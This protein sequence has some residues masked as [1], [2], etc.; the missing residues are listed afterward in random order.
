MSGVLWQVRFV[1]I[2]G[3]PTHVLVYYYASAAVEASAQKPR[4]VVPLSEVS[5]QRWG[6]DNCT[7]R[8]K[9]P[10]R[11]YEFRAH[12]PEECTEWI[13][14][15]S[16]A[17]EVARRARSAKG[18]GA[19]GGRPAMCRDSSDDDNDATD[20]ASACGSACGSGKRGSLGGTEAAYP[21]GRSAGT[22]SA[23]RACG[24]SGGS[25]GASP[26]ATRAAAATAR[27]GD[28]T[29]ASVAPA[30]GGGANATLAK[31]RNVRFT[32]F[33]QPGFGLGFR[34][35]AD[36][37]RSHRSERPPLLHSGSQSWVDITGVVL[38]HDHTS[39]RTP[40]NARKQVPTLE[41]MGG[42]EFSSAAGQA[43]SRAL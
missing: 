21:H 18:G 16:S 7:L 10:Q 39:G 22:A 29:R 2:E 27:G 24:A 25:D 6:K 19:G 5:V 37:G 35:A 20:E 14:A 36:G 9:A 12:T 11:L 34:G 4:G 3:A 1:V 42:E 33:R 26:V 43:H 23:L 31:E 8:L 15:I 41:V 28:A 17:A 30:G 13:D 32:G 40:R 38:A